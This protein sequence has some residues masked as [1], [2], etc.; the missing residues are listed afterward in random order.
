MPTFIY[1][2]NME[3]VSEA[4]RVLP[5]DSLPQTFV[6]AVVFLTRSGPSEDDRRLLLCEEI[7]HTEQ[8]EELDITNHELKDARLPLL[9][10][11]GDIFWDVFHVVPIVGGFT[12]IPEI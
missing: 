8:K 10:V 1:I 3:T 7:Q 12:G 11:R 2:E 4:L 5:R 9:R 6:L